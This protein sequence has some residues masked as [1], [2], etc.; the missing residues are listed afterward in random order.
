MVRCCAGV[1]L[2]WCGA[3]MVWGC[4]GV[5]LW[6]KCLLTVDVHSI[7]EGRLGHPIA[8]YSIPISITLRYILEERL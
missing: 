4:A 8:V 7:H 6:C 3:V 2:C 1:V 5:G